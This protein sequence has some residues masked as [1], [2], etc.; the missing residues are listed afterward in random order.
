MQNHS[1]FIH[2]SQTHEL[3]ASAMAHQLFSILHSPLPEAKLEVVLVVR[4]AALSI[5]DAGE[6]SSVKNFTKGLDILTN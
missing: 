6:A 2:V 3:G 1:F 5:P 4:G